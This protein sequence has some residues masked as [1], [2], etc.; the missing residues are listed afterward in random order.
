MLLVFEGAL[1]KWAFPSAQAQLYLVKDVILL[2]VYFGFLLD[3]RRNPT[4]IER[5]GFDQDCSSSMLYVR[6]YRGFESEQ[7]LH[8]GWSW[9]D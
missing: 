6:L 4:R 1:R 2:A 9:W 3:G 7:P 5:R 8:S